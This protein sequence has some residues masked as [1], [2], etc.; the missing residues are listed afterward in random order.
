MVT[1]ATSLRRNAD[2]EQQFVVQ[3]NVEGAFVD[4]DEPDEAAEEQATLKHEA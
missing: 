4:Y 1:P 2:A 3:T